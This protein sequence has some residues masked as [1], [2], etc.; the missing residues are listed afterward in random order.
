MTTLIPK[1]ELTGSTNRPINEKLKETVSILDFGAIGDGVTDCT[2][3]FN[4]AIAYLSQYSNPS[5]PTGGGTISN[6]TG[7]G[8]LLPNGT[9]KITSMIIVKSGIRI[10]SDASIQTNTGEAGYFGAIINNQVTSGAC[11]QMNAQTTIEGIKF[12]KEGGDQ[13]QDTCVIIPAEN[14]TIKNCSFERANYHIVIANEFTDIDPVGAIITGNQFFHLNNAS[15]ACIGI[16]GTTGGQNCTIEQNV[17]NTH[18]ELGYLGTQAIRSNSLYS[19]SNLR[20]TNNNFE[21]FAVSSDPIV[22]LPK[23]NGVIFMG[24]A[25]GTTGTAFAIAI[26]G[27]GNIIKGNSFQSYGGVDIQATCQ[28]CEIGPNYY[29]SVTIGIAIANGAAYNFINEQN[30]GLPI[31]NNATN[32]N[33]FLFNSKYSFKGDTT[34]GGNVLLNSTSLF[35]GVGVISIANATTTPTSTPTGGGV[36]YA[37]SGALKYKGSSGTITT[38]APA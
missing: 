28:N 7:G 19:V 10:Y 1:Y 29:P 14:V 16:S 3:A 32:N 30:V 12:Y 26:G 21:N 23:A 4:A 35:G 31:T 15:G 8:I 9:Y 24:N 18:G 11:F 6:T 36:L 25:F 5:N 22:N 34:F 2:A 20:I 37:D 38:I 33:V 13:Q 27:N 17:F